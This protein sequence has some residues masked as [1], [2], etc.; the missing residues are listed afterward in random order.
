MYGQQS[1]AGRRSPRANRHTAARLAIG[2]LVGVAAVALAAAPAFGA[3]A[4]QTPSGGAAPFARGTLVSRSG[5]TLDLQ[6]NN[7]DTKVIVTTSTKYAQTKT[8]DTTAVITG[9]CVRVI[10]TGSAAKGIAAQTVAVSPGTSSCTTGLGGG[11]GGGAF[12][13]GGR[14]RTGAGGGTNG[15]NGTNG[16]GQAPPGLGNGNGANGATGNGGTTGGNGG[17]GTGNGT[18]GTG[19]NFPTN[20]GTI[21]GKVTKVA[22]DKIVVKGPVFSAP[23]KKNTRPK[24][25]TKSVNVTL[26]S[27]T[28]VSQTVT[29]TDAV[30]TVGSC[31]NAAG[32]TDS[33]G[34]VTA[35]TVTVS[36]PV[37]GACTGGFGGFGGRGGFGGGQGGPGGAGG[38]TTGGTGTATNGA[39]GSA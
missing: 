35:K 25:K 17:P 13:G 26:A 14:F 32:S 5:S 18:G 39:T 27:T 29:A 12:P 15:P 28:T 11:G 24:A 31:V 36:A 37:N 33:V 23:T 22:G 19:R 34:T 30:L 4:D 9:S 6:G 3:S 7:G 38:G 10:G 20:F 21:S 1:L 2:S 16:G 8:A